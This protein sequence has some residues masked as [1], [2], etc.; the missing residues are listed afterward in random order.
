MAVSQDTRVLIV[1]DSPLEQ[2]LLAT[3]LVSAGFTT[4]I[5]ADGLEAWAILEKDPKAFDVVL[6][7]RT[8]P[9]LGGLDL[10]V[11]MKAHAK[12]RL[13]PV[14]L[15]TAAAHRDQILEGLKAGAWY[16]LTKPY[17]ADMLTA[18]VSTAASDY[19]EYRLL[20][21]RLR[22]GLDSLALVK[23]AVF[24]IR[25]VSQAR[26]VAAMLATTCPDPS[27]VVVG[28]VELLLNGI[29][30]GN[31]GITY[32]EKSHLRSRNEW[33][34]EVDRRLALPENVS[35]QVELR[36]EKTDEEIVFTIRDDGPGFDWRWFLDIDPLRAFDTH[37]RGIPMARALSFASV[38]YR[39]TGNEVVA[40]VRLP[41]E[42][43]GSETD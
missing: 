38:E 10:M 13:V 41:R 1:E 24:S 31:L 25:T 19:G 32:E 17:D 37:G 11:R 28:L 43:T 39:G 12:L 2:K 33:Q 36:Y 5:V 23:L 42:K 15:Q 8:V 30:H 9:N 40:T 7:D 6:L 22:K 14:I 4:Q 27:A 18:V 20:Q 3:Q 29:E 21:E 34:A 35:K 26:D 16:Y